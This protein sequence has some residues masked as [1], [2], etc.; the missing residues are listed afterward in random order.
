MISNRLSSHH[1]AFVHQRS[2]IRKNYKKL[3]FDGVYNDHVVEGEIFLTTSKVQ[4]FFMWNF[5]GI[6]EVSIA[7]IN[8]KGWFEKK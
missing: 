2:F 4:D 7:E 5:F 1:F 3:P 6:F 8:K